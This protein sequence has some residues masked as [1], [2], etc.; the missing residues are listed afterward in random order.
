[1]LN[2]NLINNYSRIRKPSDVIFLEKLE[3]ISSS[4]SYVNEGLLFLLNYLRR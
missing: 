1:M 3:N 2:T 4:A